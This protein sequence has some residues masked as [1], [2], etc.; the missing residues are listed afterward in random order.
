MQI[1]LNRLRRDL[2]EFAEIGYKKEAG[3][4]R[5]AFSEPDLQAREL[6]STKMEEIGLNATRDAAANIIGRWDRQTRDDSGKAI[7]IGSHL[8][9]VSNGGMF[10]GALGVLAGLECVRA[11][12]AGDYVPEHPIEIIDFSDE[13]GSHGIGTF[14]SRAMVGNLTREDIF[15]QHK[16]GTPPLAEELSSLGIDLEDTLKRGRDLEKISNYLELHVEQGPK[17]DALSKPVGVVTGI[18]G[19]S[20]YFLSIQGEADHAGTTPLQD[21]DDALVKAAKCIQEVPRIVAG[22]DKQMVGTIGELEVLPNVSNVVPGKVECLLELRSDENKNIEEVRGKVADYLENLDTRN[23]I[24]KISHTGP[25]ELPTSIQDVIASAC[26][27]RDVPY[28]HMYSYAGHDAKSFAA[29]V[30]TGMIFVPS[31]DGKSHCP[32]ECTDW[33]DIKA[34]AQILLDTIIRLDED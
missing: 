3:V 31:I 23:E 11:M 1:N 12:K 8:D 34:G 20:K 27:S 7:V 25:T 4:T 2:K 6:L 19:I 28:H 9:T 26:G 5:L 22:Q 24:K 33:E 17:L 15:K 18:V 30:P 16:P 14:G 21:R 32:D 10:D 13:E 29:E